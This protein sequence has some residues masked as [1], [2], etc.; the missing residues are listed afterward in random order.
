LESVKPIYETLP[1]WSEDL[2]KITKASDLPQ[3]FKDYIHFIEKFTESKVN[4]IS[5]GAGRE[6]V[7]DI[8]KL[9]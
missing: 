4:L 3:N 7:I 8:Q 2:T 5:T 9:F 6:H 1:G